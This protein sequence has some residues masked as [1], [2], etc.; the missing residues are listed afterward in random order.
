MKSLPP[1]VMFLRA[2]DVYL[3]IAYGESAPSA[4]RARVE[5]L[6]AMPESDFYESAVLER[7]DPRL[8]HRYCLRLG[9]ASYPH[10]KL[11]L[12]RRGSGSYAFGVEEHDHLTTT[13]SPGSR[14]WRF[15]QEMICHNRELAEKIETAWSQEGM[16]VLPR[17]NGVLAV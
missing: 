7:D 6:R 14:E 11:I 3:H 12:V 13:P 5:T 1:V 9:N 16:P 15:F 2:V 4:V 10:M 8:P 17:T